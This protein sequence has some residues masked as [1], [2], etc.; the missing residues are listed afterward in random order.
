MR[1]AIAPMLLLIAPLAAC[2]ESAVD[3]QVSETRIDDLDSLEGTISDE[4]VDTTTLNEAA[5]IDSSSSDDDKPT[6][7]KPEAKKEAEPEPKPEPA[8]EE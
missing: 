1:R 6:A 4:M 2:G 7:K 8:A 5:L 3:S